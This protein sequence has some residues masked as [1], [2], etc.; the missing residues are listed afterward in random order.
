M[1]PNIVNLAKEELKQLFIC[2][3][4]LWS[5]Y[6]H[7]IATTGTQGLKHENLVNS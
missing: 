7:Y 5:C 4:I 1:I 3:T 6:R 2:D